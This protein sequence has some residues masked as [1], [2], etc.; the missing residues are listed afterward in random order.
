VR[1][2][3]VGAAYNRIE[4]ARAARRFPIVLERI[5]EGSLTLTRGQLVRGGASVCE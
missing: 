1:H 5:A 3:A 2:L 4:A